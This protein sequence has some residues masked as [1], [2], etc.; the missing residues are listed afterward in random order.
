[1]REIGA[2]VVF[3]LR[4]LF[5]PEA[6]RE[7]A[8]GAARY[9]RD[10]FAFLGVRTPDRRRLTRL[11]DISISSE[12]ELADVARALWAEPEREFQYAGCDLLAEHVGLVGADFLDVMLELITTSSWWDTVDALAAHTVGPIV[13]E[14]PTAALTMDRWV[15]WENI[16]VARTAILHQLTF[17]ASTDQRRLFDYCGR[18]ST[19]AEFFIH[20]AIGWALRSYAATNPDAVAE[21]VATT[22]TLAPLSTREAMKGVER[23]R[24]RAD[25]REISG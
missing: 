6:D 12:A 4:E 7:W 18:R 14:H 24:R 10:Q 5:E 9:M 25:P 15:E 23:A 11:A 22:P 19:D 13:L 1:V 3:R 20:K 16:W 17:E 2:E 21:F 8:V